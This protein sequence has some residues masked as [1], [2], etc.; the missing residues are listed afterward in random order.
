MSI[1]ING[2]YAPNSKGWF[3]TPFFT[4]M[5]ESYSERI[6][7]LSIL[8]KCDMAFALDAESKIII[9][10]NFDFGS[11]ITNVLN[12]GY[13]SSYFIKY[14]P[15]LSSKLLLSKVMVGSFQAYTDLHFYKDRLFLARYIF[16]KTDWLSFDRIVSHFLERY[17]SSLCQ[18][19]QKKL[20]INDSNQRIILIDKEENI[21]VSLIE[22]SN[23]FFQSE[24]L[25]ST[26][27]LKLNTKI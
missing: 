2:V 6:G 16:D 22:I 25:N 4:S 23:S 15:H 11:N 9:S 18:R 19:V 8:D 3:S 14:F 1:E 12:S 5:I 7:Y 24:E 20:I 13:L 27:S 10:T 17:S 21:E 26:N